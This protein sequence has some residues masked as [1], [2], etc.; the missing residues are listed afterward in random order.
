MI[1]QPERLWEG[2]D[3][4]IIGGGA[5]LRKFDFN[6]LKGRNTIGC[7]DAF[8][9]G[10]DIIKACIFGDASW[11]HRTKF[12]LLKFKN[13]IFTCAPSLMPLQM[14][15]IIHLHRCR[16]GLHPGNGVGWNF[17]T[18]AAAVNLAINM[19]ARRVFL[20]GIDLMLVGGKSHWHDLRPHPTRG[21][22]FNR[23]LKGFQAIANSLREPQ[24]SH[25]Q[26]LH[27]CEG[28]SPLPFFEKVTLEHLPRMLNPCLV[29]VMVEGQPMEVVP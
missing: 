8:R 3:A 18:G 15:E 1:W 21:D 17:S 26:V 19:G 2:Q 25:V 28:Q 9:L 16:S 5:S 4:F 12:D 14:K 6:L 10:E 23:F 24:F 20:L 11:F 27:V 7:N 29:G 22:I 13:P